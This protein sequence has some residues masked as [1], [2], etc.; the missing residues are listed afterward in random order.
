[1]CLDHLLKGDATDDEFQKMGE[2]IDQCSGVCFETSL[3]ASA[4]YIA[5]SFNPKLLEIFPKFGE[6]AEK[7]AIVV[8][9][10]GEDEKAQRMARQ[11]DAISAAQCL[12]GSMKKCMATGNDQ[13]QRADNGEDRSQIKD[14][15]RKHIEVKAN[16][17]DGLGFIPKELNKTIQDA[18]DLEKN[19]VDMLFAKA[20]EAGNTLVQL[21]RRATRTR[22]LGSPTS[23]RHLHGP[24]R[25]GLP[26]LLCWPTR[27]PPTT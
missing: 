16:I 27:A 21:A 6:A 18:Y 15:M 10:A 22:S 25:Y 17:N 11:L 20:L 3:A 13:K 4:I 1:M 9:M 23:T 24:R 26:R 5:E 12:H 14:I 19:I 8:K 7:I 2:F